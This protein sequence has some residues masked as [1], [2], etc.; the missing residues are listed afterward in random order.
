MFD[1]K[2]F[3]RY[4]ALGAV[5]G[6]LWLFATPAQAETIGLRISPRGQ[7]LSADSNEPASLRFTVSSMA[8]SYNRSSALSSTGAMPSAPLLLGLP[9]DTMNARNSGMRA[10]WFP[11]NSGLH[12]S[13]GLIW[14]DSNRRNGNIFDVADTGLRSRA[15]VGVGWTAS[16]SSSSA[17]SGWRLDADVGASLSSM[18]ECNGAGSQCMNLGSA[19]LKPNSGGDGIRWNPFIS[20]GASFQY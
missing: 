20:I 7:V 13:A 16:A 5:L 1:A 2:K 19:G 18:R 14:S 3:L 12:T 17:G 11:F 4:S 15:F 9:Q 10:D 6:Q 8:L